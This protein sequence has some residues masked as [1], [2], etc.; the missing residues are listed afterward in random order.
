MNTKYNFCELPKIKQVYQ[1]WT[2]RSGIVASDRP[3]FHVGEAVILY[4]FFAI[5]LEIRNSPVLS[6]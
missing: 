2:S 1:K 4:Q 3:A 5:T 6:T